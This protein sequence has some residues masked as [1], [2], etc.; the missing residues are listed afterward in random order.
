MD[1]DLS[2]ALVSA[3]LVLLMG[4][5]LRN[6]L[7]TGETMLIY[8]RIR[9]EDAPG[10]FWGVVGTASLIIASLAILSAVYFFRWISKVSGDEIE[11]GD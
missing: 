4:Y 5:G 8:T 6:V 7:R 10:D 9:R 1:R 3:A 2:I 11:D